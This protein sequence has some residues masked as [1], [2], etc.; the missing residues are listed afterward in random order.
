M[1]GGT[2][3]GARCDGETAG[4]GRLVA[5]EVDPA[6][7]GG[8]GKAPGSIR[9]VAG[10]AAGVD[11]AGGGG[12]GKAPG[13]TLRAIFRA[14]K[15]SKAIWSIFRQLKPTK[16]RRSL[17][18]CAPKSARCLQMHQND[19]MGQDARSRPRPAP[20]R[21]PLPAPARSRMRPRPARGTRPAAACFRYTPAAICSALNSAPST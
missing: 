1:G 3:Q 12:G 14:E 6:G 9:R 13:S 8:G 4:A 7:G 21:G 19:A 5:G 18:P 20:A 15:G 16:P 11:P 10:A 2:E 17:P